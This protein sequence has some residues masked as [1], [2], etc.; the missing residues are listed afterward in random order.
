V[1]AHAT[2]AASA[3][4]AATRPTGEGPAMLQRGRL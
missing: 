2:A 3:A 1:G 4:S